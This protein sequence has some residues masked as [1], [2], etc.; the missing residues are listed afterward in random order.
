[1]TVLILN[2][3]RGSRMG[4]LTDDRPKCMTEIA[5]HETILSRQLKM[6]SA[7]GLDNIVIT[8]GYN[9]NVLK[10]YAAGLGLP[11]GTK[12]VNNPCYAVTN[13]IY[14]IYLAR[15]ELDD[16]IILMHGDLVFE[17]SVLCDVIRAEN[18]CMTVSSALPL[19][20]KDFKAVIES[21]KIV[22]IGVEFFDNA[23][24]AQPL[25]KILKADMQIW[26]ESITAF[27]ESGDDSKRRCYAENAFNAVSDR[28]SIFPLEIGS[29]LCTEIDNAADLARV[30]EVLKKC[31]K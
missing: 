5:A 8:T 17:E 3:G 23:L 21:G 29:R 10:S 14:S 13:Y 12:F 24:A 31:G 6:L 19:P 25:Y 20:Q 28:C 4:C 22:R 16:D 30:S 7:E 18:S 15:G 27:C 11:A 1:M 26:L 2:S 9:E